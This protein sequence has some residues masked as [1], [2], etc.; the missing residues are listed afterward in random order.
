MKRRSPV[1]AAGLVASLCVVGCSSSTVAQSLQ[2][3]ASTAEVTGFSSV[4]FAAPA[5]P[6]TIRIGQTSASRLALLVSRLPSVAPSQVSC[7]EPLSLMYRIVFG[8]GSVAQSKAVVKGYR[9]DAAVTITVAGKPTSWRRDSA[10]TVIRA[11]RQVLPAQA[12]GTQGQGIGCG[13]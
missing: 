12:G 7:H 3:D 9:C 10:C 5:G 13:S 11:V 4:S 1:V 8:S 6:V 2:S